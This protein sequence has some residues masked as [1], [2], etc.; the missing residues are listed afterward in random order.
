MVAEARR[1][2]CRYYEFTGQAEHIAG[3]LLTT[4]EQIRDAVTGFT[5]IG[6]DEVM[7]Y[8]WATDPDQISRIADAVF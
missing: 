8:C 1:N 5:G 6:A 2:L 4:P 3:G 7:L